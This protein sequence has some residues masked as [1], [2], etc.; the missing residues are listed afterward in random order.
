MSDNGIK[1]LLLLLYFNFVVVLSRKKKKGLYTYYFF[2]NNILKSVLFSNKYLYLFVVEL[3]FHL[4]AAYLID[5]VER[6]PII[7]MFL[8]QQVS[9][10]TGSFCVVGSLS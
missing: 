7:M 10:M 3:C 4:T 6:G 9:V 1:V 8:M 5:T 2:L